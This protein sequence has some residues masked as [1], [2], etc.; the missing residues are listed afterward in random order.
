M[1]KLDYA[2]KRRALLALLSL[3]MALTFTYSTH[4]YLNASLMQQPSKRRKKKVT[5]K[6]PRVDYTKFSHTTHVGQQKLACDSC[7]KF[8]TK[9]WKDVRKNDAFEDVAEFPEHASCLNCHRQQFFARQRP[10][11]AICSNCHVN[12]TP[13]NTARFLFPSLGDV[14]GSP[15]LKKD[16]RS[17]FVIGFPHDKH[18]DAVGVN[19]P[20]RKQSTVALVN[21][22]WQEKSKQP[23]EPK[24]CPVCHQTYQPQGSSSDEYITKPPKN[25]DDAFWLKKGTF[26]T[27]PD[28]HKTCFTCHNAELGIEPAP[29]N[30]NGCHKLSDQPHLS[31]RDFDPAVATAMG[32]TDEKTLHLWSHRRSSGTFRHEGGDHP[33]VGCLSCHHVATMNLTDAKTLVVATRSCGGADGCHI[34]A[35]ADEGGILNYEVDQ[36][37]QK[38]AFVCTKC[39]V[40]YGKDTLPASHVAAIPVAKK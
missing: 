19:L 24:S 4:A 27:V 30:C 37:K 22:S 3:G 15:Q 25:L 2:K 39:H 8:P 32:I 13:R 12:V 20:N 26:K 40:S 31:K 7:H 35:T 28:S 14:A 34:T 6:G 1:S 5:P 11:P 21:V 18:L 16:S 29:A 10:A 9:N 17:E 23:A 33:N 38:A 36:K